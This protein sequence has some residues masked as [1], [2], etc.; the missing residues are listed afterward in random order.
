MVSQYV[1]LNQRQ[2][3]EKKFGNLLQPTVM[4]QS[5]SGVE[6][7]TTFTSIEYDKV[8]PAVFELPPAIKALVK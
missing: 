7:I 4:K 3:T 8:D 2:S 6:I 1:L 5:T